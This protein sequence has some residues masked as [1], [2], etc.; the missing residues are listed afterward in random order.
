MNSHRSS[1][2]ETTTSS[3]EMIREVDSQG[4]HDGLIST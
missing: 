2:I 1:L 4:K 3:L